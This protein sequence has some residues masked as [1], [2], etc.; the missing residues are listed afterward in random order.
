MG[1]GNL[2]TKDYMY[3]CGECVHGE[4]T[5]SKSY[6]FVNGFTPI[7]KVTVPTTGEQVHLE[8]YY[9]YGGQTAVV[10]ED[11][12]INPEDN[13]LF[14]GDTF[15]SKT[16]EVCENHVTLEDN[17]LVGSGFPIYICANGKSGAEG[18]VTSTT[19]IKGNRFARCL[20]TPF[21][22][23]ASG[24]T[25][26]GTGKTELAEGFP[27]VNPGADAYG[28]WPQDG[29]YGLAAI[30][31]SSTGSFKTGGSRVWEDNFWDNNLETCPEIEWGNCT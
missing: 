27:T 15:D 25:K 19:T 1:A 4:W 29:Y 5:V 30:G 20:G 3:N 9:L 7:S 11:T 23:E 2:A 10:K 13:A 31:Y 21:Y 24:G 8:G 26:C 28:Y 16:S 22:E 17:F 12:I 6:L 18:E 14:F